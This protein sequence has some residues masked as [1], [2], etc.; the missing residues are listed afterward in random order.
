MYDLVGGPGFFLKVRARPPGPAH[1]ARP[2]WTRFLH[3]F[4]RVASI[5]ICFAL[6]FQICT[7]YT[8]SIKYSAPKT[9]SSTH[10]KTGSNI[11]PAGGTRVFNKSGPGPAPRSGTPCPAGLDPYGSSRGVAPLTRHARIRIERPLRGF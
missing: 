5:S 11:R 4:T 6:D 2:A 9:K 7:Q 8:S 1:H 3:T 10:F